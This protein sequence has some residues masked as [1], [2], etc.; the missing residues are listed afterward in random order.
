MWRNYE[1]FKDNMKVL[2]KGRFKECVLSHYLKIDYFLDKK[3]ESVKAENEFDSR[4]T[5][6]SSFSFTSKQ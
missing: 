1:Q 3:Y 6:L 4:R 2:P 5:I